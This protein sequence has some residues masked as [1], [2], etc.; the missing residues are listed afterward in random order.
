LSLT[1]SLNDKTFG[2]GKKNKKPP[3]KPVTEEESSVMAD[4]KAHPEDYIDWS[5]PWTLNI[6]YNMRYSN[7]L[8][9]VDQIW[10]PKKTIVQTLGVTGNIS[11]TPKWK[12][13]FNTG[14]DFKNKGLAFTSL[15]LV[16]DLHCWEMRFNWIPLGARKSWNFSLNIKASILQDLKLTKKK[17]F[18][19]I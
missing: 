11:I 16:R 10:T 9:Y 5:I 18:R 3:E 14:W 15:N 8:S 1:L 12:F 2:K 7:V 6:R 4:I 17:D 19:D 13:S